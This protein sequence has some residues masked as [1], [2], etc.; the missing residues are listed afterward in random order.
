MFEFERK[1][2]TPEEAERP[3]QQRPAPEREAGPSE[4]RLSSNGHLP[5]LPE[6]AA[7]DKYTQV[8]PAVR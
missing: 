7:R 1:I 2:N 5:P 8:L 3:S 4:L 6:L